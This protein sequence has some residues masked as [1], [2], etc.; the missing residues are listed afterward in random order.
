MR[1]QRQTILSET[2][3]EKAKKVFLKYAPRFFPNDSLF[4]VFIPL[5]ADVQLQVDDLKLELDESA[6]AQAAPRDVPPEKKARVEDHPAPASAALASAPASSKVAGPIAIDMDGDQRPEDK[7]QEEKD[8]SIVSEAV[9]WFDPLHGARFMLWRDAES[10]PAAQW[11]Q[12]EKQFRRL[13]KLARRF[14]CVLPTSAPSERVWSG[15]GHVITKNSSTIDST[16]AAKIMF[17]RH[18]KDMLPFII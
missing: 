3:W 12:L 7:K 8:Q 17:L 14:L 18:N 2:Q 11:R 4:P 16:L 9:N 10:Q 1:V 6:A 15:F 13:A 5:S